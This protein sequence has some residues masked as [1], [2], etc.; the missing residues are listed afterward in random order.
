MALFGFSGGA[1]KNDTKQN[2]NTTSATT[3]NEATNQATQRI[4]QSTI[5][6]LTQL[7]KD[8][9]GSIGQGD[10]KLSKEAAITDTQGVVKNLFDT[11]SKSVLP[12]VMQKA[13]SSGGYNSTAATL[14]AND[15][16]AQ[17]V[18]KS[19]EV[20][21]GAIS[22]YA[23]ANTAKEGLKNNSLATVLQTLLG[24]KEISNLVSSL[25]SSTKSSATARTTSSGKNLS[26]GFNPF[27]K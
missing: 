8:I 10:P 4:D 17:T 22:Q 3:G 12:Q 23:A 2:S 13:F 26:G 11:F 18:N 21:L 5:D 14:L 20:Q 19:A 9:S 24:S 27:G 25:D 15:A 6:S 7:F 1:S 16:F